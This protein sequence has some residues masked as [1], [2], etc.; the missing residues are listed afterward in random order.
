MT[1]QVSTINV[2]VIHAQALS[3]VPTTNV[4]AVDAAVVFPV[5]INALVTVAVLDPNVTPV[6]VRVVSVHHL[7][8]LVLAYLVAPP[9]S[10]ME[11]IAHP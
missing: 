7:E 5:H 2:T 6:F 1:Q 9:A 8:L 3:T 10:V 4:K 11:N